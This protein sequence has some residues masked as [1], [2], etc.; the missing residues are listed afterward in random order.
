MQTHRQLL[1]IQ[2][3]NAPDPDDIMPPARTL[4]TLTAQQKA[5]LEK[6]IASG[7]KY[8]PHWSFI[9]PVK[10]EVPKVKNR[11]W[12]HNPI[13]NFV[14]AKL[15]T[16]RL[17]TFAREAD[18][19]RDYRRRQSR[20]DLTGLPPAPRPDVEAFVKDTSPNA[21]EK[22]VDRLLA[23]PKYG[24]HR[25]RYWLDAARYGDTHGIHVDNYREI[26]SYRDWVINALNHNK[27]FDQFTLEQLAGDLLPDATLDQKIA[28]GFN[29]CNITTSEG[30]AIDEEYLVLYARDRTDTTCHVW[31]GLTAGCA[32]CHD[33]KFDPL[34]QKEFYSLTAFFNNTTQKAMDGNV[35]D[36]PPAIPVPMAT[37]RA[38]W[39]AIA[40]TLKAGERRMDARRKSGHQDYDKWLPTAT[41][42]M[43]SDR[44]PKDAPLFSAMLDDDMPDDTN[45]AQTITYNFKGQEHDLT[46]VKN[47]AWQNG[48]VAAKAL[49][50]R[51]DIPIALP[52]VGNFDTTNAFSYGAWVFLAG[53]QDGAVISR[54][55]DTNNFRGWDLWFEGAKPGTHIVSKWPDDALK[56]VA[57][58]PITF[59]RWTHVFITYDGSAKAAGVKIYVDGEEQLT[60]PQGGH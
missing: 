59:K 48:I 42:K 34:S 53:D 14:L 11:R 4:K 54:M 24:E 38:E 43:F 46:L 49:S 15:R 19:R 9:A 16:V 36:T 18:K 33:H 6:W 26:W 7:A 40:P 60:T 47:A 23:S 41:S 17:E 13:D 44:M 3:I 51:K 58:K 8:Q 55:D 32:V 12:I 35:K 22:L 10:P 31:L 21:Y 25:A 5:T 28:T 45:D 2:R 20:S 27:P 29:R 50:T 56:V 39:D 37:D 1:A 30:G 52:E 57:N